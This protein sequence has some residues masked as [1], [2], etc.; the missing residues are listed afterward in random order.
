MIVFETTISHKSCEH[1]FLIPMTSDGAY[2]V[3]EV[4]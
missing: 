4:F 1:R 3:D 2:N